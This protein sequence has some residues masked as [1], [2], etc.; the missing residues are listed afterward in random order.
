LPSQSVVGRQH[1]G[2]TGKKIKISKI[3]EA[4]PKKKE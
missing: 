3:P 4:F 1:L 2:E